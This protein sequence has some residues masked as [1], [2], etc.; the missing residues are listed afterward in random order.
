MKVPI[1]LLYRT[2]F[3][4]NNT[5]SLRKLFSVLSCANE[6][7]TTSLYSIIYLKCAVL[8]RYDQHN[9]S[10]KT[11]TSDVFQEQTETKEKKAKKSDEMKGLEDALAKLKEELKRVV[12]KIEMNDGQIQKTTKELNNFLSRFQEEHGHWTVKF[13]DFFRGCPD[14]MKEPTAIAL[15]IKLKQLDSEKSRLRNEEWNIKTKQLD[16]QLQLA[17]CK[18]RLGESLYDFIVI[19]IQ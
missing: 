9:Q 15:D 4:H 17:N 2:T 13:L 8:F 10:V 14:A 3:V 5:S 1:K 18:I 19:N 7:R 16:L 12:E 6:I 11:C